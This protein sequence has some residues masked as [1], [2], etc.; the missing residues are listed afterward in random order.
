M[1]INDKLDGLIM[2]LTDI[3]SLSDAVCESVF[4]SRK[5]DCEEQ[6]LLQ[7]MEGMGGNGTPLSPTYEEDPYFRTPESAQAYVRMKRIVYG[8]DVPP[9][10]SPNLYLNGYFYGSLY[11]NVTATGCSMESTAVFAD[12]IWQKYGRE[13]F[14]I[15]NEFYTSEIKPEIIMELK[16]L[17]IA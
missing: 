11:M 10:G 13:N 1:K 6:V 5:G 17:L 8:V 12:D 15:S 9:N 4:E 16:K 14:G 7:L 2:K 3:A